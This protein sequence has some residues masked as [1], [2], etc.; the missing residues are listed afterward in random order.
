MHPGRGNAS[1]SARCRKDSHIALHA[2]GHPYAFAQVSSIFAMRH[3]F[4]GASAAL[5]NVEMT[6][7]MTN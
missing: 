1:I 6:T 4:G 2:C 7:D 3:G 5:G